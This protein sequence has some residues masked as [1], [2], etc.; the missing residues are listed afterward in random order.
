MLPLHYRYSSSR[1]LLIL[2]CVLSVHLASAGHVFTVAVE[3]TVVVRVGF[4]AQTVTVTTFDPP[5]SPLVVGLPPP[6]VL[7]TPPVVLDP[8]PLLGGALIFRALKPQ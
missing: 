4:A 1:S 3:N 8:P 6:P 7:G 5:P 2:P